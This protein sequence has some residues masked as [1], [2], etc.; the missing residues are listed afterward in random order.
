MRFFS[1][2]TAAVLA[3]ASSVLAQDVPTPD[4]DA[5]NVPT[6]EQTIQAGSTFQ[7]TWTT[8]DK[9]L[10]TTIKISL[11]GGPN[12]KGLQPLGD[13]ASKFLPNFFGPRRVQVGF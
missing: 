5:V 10:A 9:Y 12:Q 11:I 13:I 3:F 4:F 6:P 1:L 8:T 7:V 2:T